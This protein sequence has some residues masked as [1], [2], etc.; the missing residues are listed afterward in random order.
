M[1]LSMDGPCE[2]EGFGLYGNVRELCVFGS[3]FFGGRGSR[4]FGTVLNAANYRCQRHDDV[5]RIWLHFGIQ[6]DVVCQI[7]LPLEFFSSRQIQ[8]R[9]LPGVE[10]QR[11]C[12]SD[13]NVLATFVRD[14]E[15]LGESA[16]VKN[17]VAIRDRKIGI[18]TVNDGYR[19]NLR[20]IR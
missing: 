5:F 19:K 3:D 7:E 16:G 20:V 6:I 4:S 8:E 18:A 13:W 17:I 11:L 14:A 2:F 10:V 9:R 12:I 1:R 15:S